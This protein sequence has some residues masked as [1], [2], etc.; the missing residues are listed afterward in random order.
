MPLLLFTKGNLDLNPERSV[1]IVGTRK[2]TLYGKSVT[3]DIIASLAP[4]DGSI[5]RG[6]AYGIDI[7]AHRKSLEYNIPTIGVMGSGMGNIYPNTHHSV[8]QKMMINVGVITEFNY[9]TGLEAV[10]SPIG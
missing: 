10:S 2:P 7:T 6:L 5:I 4:Y 9:D 3:E 1:S 8:A